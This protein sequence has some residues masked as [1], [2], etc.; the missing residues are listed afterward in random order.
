LWAAAWQFLQ[1]FES[2]DD[3]ATGQDKKIKFR[4]RWPTLGQKFFSEVWP[5]EPV[6]QSPQSAN[7]FARIPVRVGKKYYSGAILKITP[8]LRPFEI[9]DVESAFGLR[10][11]NQDLVRE[12]PTETLALIASCV[13]EDQKHR[14]LQ[15]GRVLSLIGE[16]NPALERDPEFRRLRRLVGA[17]DVHD[18]D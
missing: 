6:A 16:T 2:K 3:E 15:L 17:D 18:A 4:N 1:L 5:M 12:H 13:P 10:S 9:W 14:I 7:D 11:Q 8:F